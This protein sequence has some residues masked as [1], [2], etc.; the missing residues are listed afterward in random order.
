MYGKDWTVEQDLNGNGFHIV[1]TDGN[2]QPKKNPYGIGDVT[3]DKRGT[4]A[5]YNLDKM[6]VELI[7]FWV[8]DNYEREQFEGGLTPELDEALSILSALAGW[9]LRTRSAQSVLWCMDDPWRDAAAVFDYGAKKYSDWNWAKGMPW[10]V[11]AACAVRHLL[12]ILRGEHTDA[13]SGL[14]HIGHVASNL[15]MLAHF[16]V[17]YR[18]GDD[19]PKIF[20]G[21]QMASLLG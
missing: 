4:G 20:L 14:P 7:P 6:R 9:Q 13:E 8:I 10:S 19:R 2:G 3:S 17:Y 15:V 5:R 12:A 18:E 1:Y 11:P 16:E 21:N